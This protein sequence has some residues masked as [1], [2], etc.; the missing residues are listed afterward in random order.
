M[1]KVIWNI[2]HYLIYGTLAYLLYALVCTIYFIKDIYE[3]IYPKS[4]H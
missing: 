1:G 4:K 2:K 3:N